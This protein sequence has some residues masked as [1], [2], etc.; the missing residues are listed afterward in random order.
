M[1][2]SG[3]C[4]KQMR[5]IQFFNPSSVINIRAQVNSSAIANISWL[6]PTFKYQCCGFQVHFKSIVMYNMK[7]KSDFWSKYPHYIMDAI[8]NLGS[9]FFLFSLV[10][11]FAYI[12]YTLCQI[13]MNTCSICDD[14]TISINKYFSLFAE[15]LLNLFWW[16][17]VSYFHPVAPFTNMNWQ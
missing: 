8:I 14:V 5:S 9:T 11:N 7:T 4:V 1:L 6:K 3:C 2:F 13:E 15:V 10:L 16:V 12:Y 17:Y